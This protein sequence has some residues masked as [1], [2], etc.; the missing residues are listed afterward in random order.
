MSR[1][2]EA[3][4]LQSIEKRGLAGVILE[5]RVSP[6]TRRQGEGTNTRPKI[7]IRISFFDHSNPDNQ[8]MLAPILLAVPGRCLAS[9]FFSR[10]SLSQAPG[11]RSQPRRRVS[12]AHEI[13]CL[14]VR[15]SQGR[16]VFEARVMG[17]GGSCGLTYSIS[18]EIKL[19]L[20]CPALRKGWSLR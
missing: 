8:D 4:Y 15:F 19:S 14:R 20:L 2:D 13:A 12:I 9:P 6:A 11:P 7:S 3:S 18:F 10:V 17:R 5:P 1:G 16:R